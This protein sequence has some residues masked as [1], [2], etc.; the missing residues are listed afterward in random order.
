MKKLTRLLLINWHYF[1]N[2]IIDL[3][4]INFLTGKN[5]AGK[6][7]IIDALQVVLMGETRSVAFNRAASKKSE[8]T[9][10]SYL[11]GS[12]GE[13]IENG[14]KSVRDGKDFSTYIVAEFYD[15]FKSSYFC[16]GAVFDSFSDSSDIIKRFFWLQSDIPANRFIENGKTMDSRRMTQYFKENY[17]NKY[18]TKDTSEG[19]RTVVLGR[20]NIHNENFISMLKKAISFEPIN[21]IEKFIT[22]NICDIED[23]IDIVSMQENILYYKNQE[24]MTK[25]FEGKLNKLEEICRQYEE[26]TGLR[27][28]RK[29]QQ[30][31]IDY[32]LCKH[33]SG[34]LEES[35]TELKKY[36]DDIEKHK[37]IENNIEAKIKQLGIERDELLSDKQKFISD[38]KID[39]L[40]KEE[41]RIRTIIEEYAKSLSGFIINIK[42]GSLSWNNKLNNSIKIIDDVNIHDDI[43]NILAYLERISSFSEDDFELLSVD[44]FVKIR[45]EYI[46]IRDSLD[47]I[48]RKLSSELAELRNEKNK[49]EMQIKQLKEGKKPYPDKAVKLRQILREELKKKY[50]TDIPVDFLADKIE[51]QDE[52]WHNAVEGYLNTQRMN[53]I[54]PPNY[55]M[56]AYHIYRT[57]RDKEDIFEYA[58][59]DL[60]KVY[61][62]APKKMNNSLAEIVKS[63]DKYVQAYINYLLGKVIKCYSDDT[64]RDYRTSVTKDCMLYHNYAVKSLNPKVYTCPYI[65]RNSI[66]VQIK[67]LTQRLEDIYSVIKEKSEKDNLIVPVLKNEWFLAENYI[68]STVVTAFNEFQKRNEYR[69]KLTE[70]QQILDSI[71][72]LWLEK[73]DQKIDEK[74][75]EID[76]NK[77]VQKDIIKKITILENAKDNMISVVIPEL[78]QKKSDINEKIDA[79]YSEEYQINEGVP[80]YNFEL[81]E[82]G[83][84]KNVADKFF[85][86]IKKIALAIENKEKELCDK[87]SNYNTEERTAFRVSDVSSNDEYEESYEKIKDYELPKYYEKIKKAKNDAMEQFKS[88]FIYKLRANI[89]SVEMKIDELN[90]ALKMAKFGNDSYMFE[91]KPNPAYLEYYNMIMSPLLDDGTEGLFGYEFSERYK[92]IIDNLFEQIIS[93]DSNSVKTAQSV[94]M[95]SR[96]QTYLTFDMITTDSNGRRERLSKSIHT[97][98]GGETQTPFYIA[99]LA[100]FAQLYRVNDLKET[101]NTFRLVVFDE[102]FNKMDSERIIE[103]VNLLRKFKLQAIICSPPEKAADIAPIADKTQLVYKEAVEGIYKSTVVEWTKE[104]SDTYGE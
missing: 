24:V 36:S 71:D 95:F 1:Q 76:G 62:D 51:I 82:C 60:Q 74:E 81:S 52:E 20:L 2:T 39:S 18:E 42:T 78:I 15:D 27:L 33:Y 69:E 37:Q 50:S 84:H 83:S 77:Q 53:I 26:I 38:N 21:D 70:I 65:G 22:E 32:G 64:L 75:S 90:D 91:V 25:Q 4:V 88:D 93:F 72:L 99:V 31:L 103:S 104:M 13:D 17:P 54:V 12:M 43:K 19:Y 68:S 30:F 87:R 55:F 56:E 3:G 5:S 98:S 7:T 14:N 101:G 45:E 48:E 73:I 63:E 28:Q 35:R 58:I 94:K 66:E 97:K 47:K 59:V 100:S 85:V 29:I 46:K 44:Y 49:L 10:K 11:I 79:E 80:K 9:L 67:K 89:Q 96:Y 16:L 34:K 8:R 23:D 102:A 40:Q 6:S 41:K 57:V 61:D 92:T 86:S